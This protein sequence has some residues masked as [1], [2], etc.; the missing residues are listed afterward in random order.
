VLRTAA[1][2]RD[3]LPGDIIVARTMDPSWTP[4]LLRAAGVV[5]EEGGPLSHAAIVAREFGIPAV[6]N[7]PGATRGVADGDEIEVD[8]SAGTVARLAPEE[9]A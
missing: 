7:V 3:L 9:A 2:G 5:L 1:D 8:G 4:L 6:M